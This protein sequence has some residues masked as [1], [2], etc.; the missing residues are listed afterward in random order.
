MITMEADANRVRVATRRDEDELMALCRRN[1]LENGVGDFNPDKV[2]AVM[3][4]AFL[5]GCNEP[6]VIGVVGS[7]CIEGSVGIIVDTPWDGDTPF[8]QALWNY[9]LPECRK[10]TTLR[11]LI[12]FAR[13]LSE[14]V[15]IGIGLPLKMNIP[16]NDHTEHQIRIYKRQLGEPVN[17]TWLCGSTCGSARGSKANEARAS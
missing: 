16:A 5:P 1:H 3:R 2:Y 6:A 14:P 17:L 9:V 8:L 7:A 10:S 4:R 15:P 11:D 13:R 12:A